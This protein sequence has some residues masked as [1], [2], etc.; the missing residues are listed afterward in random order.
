MQSLGGYG[1]SRPFR[2]GVEEELLLVDPVIH[3]LDCRCAEVVGR[4]T[5]TAGHACGEFS[6]AVIELVTPICETAE[7]AA[8]RLRTLRAEAVAAGATLMGAGLHPRARHGDVRRNA[9]GRYDAIEASVRGLMKRTPH[10]GVHMHVGMPDADTAVRALNGMRRWLPLLQALAANAPYWHGIDSGLASARWS[11]LRSLPRCGIPRAFA[12]H[13]DYDRTIAG[14]VA[15]AELEDY[16]YLWWDQRLHPRLGT[17]EIRAIDAQASIDD[18]AALSALAHGLA[19]HEAVGD[20]EA[21]QPSPEVLEETAFRAFRDGRDARLE[22]E[23]RI[24]PVSEIAADA[25]AIAR[26]YVDPRPLEGITRIVREGNGADR[27][28]LAAAA[29]GMPALLASLV[30]ETMPEQAGQLGHVAEDGIP[31]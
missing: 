29:G 7:E 6:Q 16:T 13:D 31:A 21:Y 24:R 4:G 3:D 23:G 12:D 8:R 2:L 5:F 20:H 22:L 14:I 30:A 25:V 10:C 18:L 1:G 15:A 17:L 11:L 26:R 27:Q 28:R 19:I 9:S